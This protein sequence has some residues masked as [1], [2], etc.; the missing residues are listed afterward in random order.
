MDFLV[1]TPGSTHTFSSSATGTIPVPSSV[2]PT[3]VVSTTVP[4]ETP[5][6]PPTNCYSG[7]VR[8]E[9]M[10]SISFP[11]Q[12]HARIGVP[13]ICVDGYFTGVCGGISQNA[14]DVICRGLGLENGMNLVSCVE[15]FIY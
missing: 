8:I 10:G 1:S 2:V 14:A 13:E 5:T 6:V 15:S 7:Q 12:T 3:G 9:G 4:T 11:N